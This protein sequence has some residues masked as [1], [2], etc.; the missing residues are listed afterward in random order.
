[1]VWLLF[2]FLCDRVHADTELNLPPVVKFG[3]PGE[4]LLEDSIVAPWSGNTGLNSNSG[5]IQSSM[6]DQLA[7]PF[8]DLGRAG[9]LGQIR[10]LGPSAEDVDVQAFGISLNP[11]QGGGFNL[12]VFPQ[13]LWSSFQY[14]FGP[15]MN[16]VNQTAATGTFTLIPWTAQ[17]LEEPGS[18]IRATEFYSTMG[19][20]QVSASFRK[21]DS[22]AVVAG[23]SSGN[24][25]GPSTSLSKRWTKNGYRGAFHLLATDVDAVTPGPINDYFPN[26]RTRNTRI[27][28]ILQSDF[29]VTQNSLFKNSVFYDWASLVAGAADGGFT[30]HTQ[31]QQ[32]G[33]ENVYLAGPWKLGVNA[34]RV[35]YQS[36]FFNAPQQT[37]GNFQ[38]SRLMESS[39]VSVDPSVQGVWVTGYGFLPEGSL[40]GKVA[41][42]RARQ[43]VF[44]RATYSRRIPSLMDRYAVY[45]T[46]VG[47]PN[48]QIETDWTGVLGWEIKRDGMEARLQ[49]YGQYRQNVRVA[50]ATSVTNLKDAVILALSGTGKLQ[51]NSM[52]DVFNSS[53]LSQSR[54]FLTGI[55]FPY[56][57]AFNNVLGLNF[58][59]KGSSANWEWS[60]VT[61]FVGP[62]TYLPS[63][64]DKLPSYLVIDTGIR[65]NL[66]PGIFLAGRVEN[67]FNRS[68]EIIKDYPLG[69]S[70]SLLV[71]GEL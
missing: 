52:L 5:S 65:K 68:I 21:E 24:L 1:M 71:T 61:R 10:G 14:Q 25:K 17:A 15:A 60:T 39:G 67:L 28:P 23:Y 57:P 3:T 18:G 19:V 27:I 66:G 69:R 45:G 38:L 34:R 59:S 55:E 32:W 63:A 46:Y 31:M 44:S 36:D 35:N 16:S 48:L 22:I 30:F 42:D 53:T 29:Q 56:V 41:W 43:S 70:V 7:I 49:A 20:N 64:N 13:F 40:G 4:V 12:S 26:Q 6:Q 58:H 37:I 50:T 9:D 54:L 8:T 47:N 2:L 62:R 51:L 11:P 33:T